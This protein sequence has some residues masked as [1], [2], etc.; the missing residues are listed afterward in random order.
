MSVLKLL[1]V[2]G[3]PVPRG[4]HWKPQKIKETTNFSRKTTLI[5]PQS[6]KLHGA[7][8]GRYE[9]FVACKFSFC[10]SGP[11]MYAKVAPNTIAF[12]LKIH[13]VLISARTIAN[14]D[15]PS[16][17]LNDSHKCNEKRKHSSWLKSK[18][19]LL[20]SIHHIF[21]KRQP[22]WAGTSYNWMMTGRCVRH[23]DGWKLVKWLTKGHTT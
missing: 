20:P 15:T 16:F 9:D 6:S 19:Y 5:R 13:L 8:V 2:R 23:L 14:H 21:G 10:H 17:L 7:E 11:K 12:S 4:Q 18:T 1:Y 22:F 3:A